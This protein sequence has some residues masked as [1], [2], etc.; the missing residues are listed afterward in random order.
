[1]AVEQRHHAA[2]DL[3]FLSQMPLYYDDDV[4]AALCLLCHAGTDML[5]PGFYKRPDQCEFSLS[6]YW[7]NFNH[8][9]RT[10]DVLRLHTINLNHMGTDMDQYR[11]CVIRFLYDQR[12]SGKYAIGAYAYAKATM[13]F[14][15]NLK[16]IYWTLQERIFNEN[17]MANQ[18]V[19]NNGLWTLNILPK[20]HPNATTSYASF[21]ASETFFL[22]LGYILFFLPHAG[23]YAPLLQLCRQYTIPPGSGP[24]LFPTRTAQVLQAMREYV[25]RCEA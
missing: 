19:H 21:T 2:L 17:H 16:L 12:R 9:N 7:N 18:L 11:S 22:H 15:Q 13:T 8:R 1:L 6:H 3:V 24:I 20:R 23:R 14:I 25:E 5:V 4:T 10:K